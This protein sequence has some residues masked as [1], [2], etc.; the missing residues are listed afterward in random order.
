MNLGI[1]AR[2]WEGRWTT[3]VFAQNRNCVE[4]VGGYL[5]LAPRHLGLLGRHRSLVGASHRGMRGSSRHLL[6]AAAVV[7]V[8]LTTHGT[9]AASCAAPH[10]L[11]PPTTIF[12]GRLVGEA[13]QGAVDTLFE[14]TVDS[15]ERG[16]VS[17]HAV[18][19]ISV[20]QRVRTPNGKVVWRS[21]S[22]SIGPP[23]LA[24][25]AYRVE[26]YRAGPGGDPRLL[27]VNACGGSL[28]LL[29]PAP[30]LQASTPPSTL[31]PRQP[32]AVSLLVAATPLVVVG[33]AI[34]WLWTRARA[35]PPS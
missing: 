8:G 19:N 34:S 17:G 28:S 21:F 26:A 6:M 10:P 22:N 32:R 33:A 2:L 13:G 20:D 11:T 27:F 4:G 25:A 9:A 16:D 18:V 24:G 23:P 35:G 15:V 5:G 30:S 3:R 1:G 12:T 29:A 14:F 31:G 7:V